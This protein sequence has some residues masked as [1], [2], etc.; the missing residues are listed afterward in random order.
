MPASH[1]PDFGQPLRFR[2]ALPFLHR[3]DVARRF[4]QPAG[5]DAGHAVA[6]LGVAQGV[7]FGRDVDRQVAFLQHPVG[8]ILERG[9]DVCGRHAQRFGHALQHRLRLFL[10]GPGR[11]L[12]GDQV[13]VDPDR[14]TVAPPVERKGPARQRLARIP[15]A[16]T[17][18]Q[19]AAGGEARLQPADQLVG[20][21]PFRRADGAGVPF[22]RL[23]I[24]DGHEGRLAAHG[25]AH[26]AFLQC[27]VH[28]LPQRIQLVPC[29][30][31]ERLGDARMLRH[32]GDSHV[33]VEGDFGEARHARDRGRVAVMRRRGQR[34]VAFPRQQARSGIEADPAGAGQIDLAPGM[35]VG[36]IDLRPLRAADG[37]QV[38]FQ[39]DQV[40]GHEPRGEAQMPQQVHQQPAGVAAGPLGKL[41]RLLRRLH[42][43]FQPHDVADVARQ[44]RVQAHHKVDGALRLAADR[45]QIV[46]EQRPLVLRAQVDR[47]IIADR[48]GV[49]EGVVLRRILHE[50][51]EGIVDAHVRDQI[52]LD[53]QLRHRVGKDVARLPVAVGVLLVV[54]EV[55]GRRHLQA[56]AQHRGAAVRRGAQTDDLRP[57]RDGAVVLVM[58]QVVDRG[59]DRH[60]HPF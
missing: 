30:V 35:Q 34:D 8:G 43:G 51:V 11:I 1:F 28:R 14:F 44:P 22:L 55:I 41:Q 16:L 27:G 9:D 60:G 50:E 19:E 3:Q 26:V 58:R 54:H 31:R 24:V 12:G 23:E 21:D 38:R 25:Q 13:G 20:E 36:E 49:G 37:L 5:K 33:E 2:P 48:V 15:L 10:R 47:Q 53:L 17:V 39:L 6:R 52:D 57:Q 7:V 18:V 32:A 4:R 45:R 40:A 46:A 56:V 59:E 29:R 42:A